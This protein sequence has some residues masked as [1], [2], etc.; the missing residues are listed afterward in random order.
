MFLRRFYLVCGT[1]CPR[2]FLSK[3]VM[4][5]APLVNRCMQSPA[6][7]RGTDFTRICMRILLLPGYPFPR[8]PQVAASTGQPILTFVIKC[9]GIKEDGETYDTRRVQCFAIDALAVSINLHFVI[10]TFKIFYD[11]QLYVTKGEVTLCELQQTVSDAR[12][13]HAGAQGKLY[14]ASYLNRL[15]FLFFIAR[16]VDDAASRD[17]LRHSAIREGDSP[18]ASLYT[19]THRFIF[20]RERCIIEVSPRLGL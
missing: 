5:D 1:R 7:S 18:P 9:S 20:M 19:H 12:W 15:Y 16:R 17:I 8:C 14:S 13:T 11:E 6:A 10:L 4:V 3:R 2:N